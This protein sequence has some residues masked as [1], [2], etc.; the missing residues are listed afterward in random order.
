[1]SPQPDIFTAALDRF[2]SEQEEVRAAAAFAA[3][4]YHTASI[5]SDGY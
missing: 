3:G 1:M 4:P 2:G 5:L